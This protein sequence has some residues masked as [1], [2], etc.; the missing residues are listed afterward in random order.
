MGQ[1]TGMSIAHASNMTDLSSP[2]ELL[3]DA[4]GRTVRRART[5]DTVAEMMALRETVPAMEHDHFIG[6]RSSRSDLSCSRA[7]PDHIITNC[8]DRTPQV[9]S[10]TA[11]NRAYIAKYK[12]TITPTKAF[13]IIYG[14]N[15]IA[16]GAMLFFLLLNVGPMQKE[17]KEIWI[18]IDSQILNALF[19]LTS[20]G[21]APWRVRDTY[22]LIMWRFGSDAKSKS[23]IEQLARRNA[24]WLRMKECDLIE[25]H[26][27]ILSQ[28]TLTGK[29]APPTKTWKIDFV[30]INL[31]LNSLFQVGMATFM[32]MYNRHNRPSF[33]VGLFIGLGCF[34]SLLAGAMSWS[35]ARKIKL[36]EG[37]KVELVNELV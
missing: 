9:S 5:Q 3:Y 30:V 4:H 18:E 31:L 8:N 20:W 33:G 22:W 16:W 1:V 11:L 23:S 24:G 21:L 19:C 25:S 26:E 2:N 34:S 36:I 13:I 32:W 29:I 35:E 14:I 28:N 6:R 37:P 15:I 12:F 10:S 17:Q 7:S 27:A